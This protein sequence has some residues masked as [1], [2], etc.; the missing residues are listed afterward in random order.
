MFKRYGL[1]TVYLLVVFVCGLAV[2]GFGYRL[3]QLRTV[4]ASQPPPPRSPEEF[5]KRHLAELTRRLNLTPDQE[6]KLSSIMDETRARTDAFFKKHRSE[7][8]QIQSEQYEKVKAVLTPVQIAEY[9]KIRAERE[10]RRRGRGG[11]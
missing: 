8:D 7:M 3:Y 6:G 1:P 10:A 4:S 5:K 9:D 2:G 11:F